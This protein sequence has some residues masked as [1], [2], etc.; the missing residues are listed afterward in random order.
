MRCGGRSLFGVV[1]LFAFALG[2]GAQARAEGAARYWVYWKS[3]AL[4]DGSRSELALSPRAVDRLGRHGRTPGSDP[5][6]YVVPRATLAP[7]LERGLVI[8]RISRFLQAAS[9]EMTADQ[10][11][12]LAVDPRILDVRPVARF[13]RPLEPADVSTSAPMPGSQRRGSA[14]DTDPRTLL[15]GDYGNAWDQLDMLGVQ[16]L[17]DRGYSG[18]GV[19]V[20]IFDTGFYKVHESLSGLDLIAEHDF[21]CGD[22]EVQW[23]PG[24][25]CGVSRSNDHGTYTWSTLGGFAPGNLIG[26]AYRA[27][28]A[29]AKTEDVSR[30]VHQEED[31]YVAALE[32]ADSLGADVVSSSLGYRAFDDGSEYTVAQL[33]GRTAPIT[34]ATDVAAD[35]GILVVTAMGNEGPGES[36]LGVPADGRRVVSVGAVDERGVLALFSSWGPTGDGRIKPD[37]V[38]MGVRTACAASAG[39]HVYARVNGTSLSTPLAAGLAALLIEAEPAWGPDSV[40]AALRRSGDRHEDPTNTMGWGVPDGVRALR[41]MD[42]RPQI[43]GVAWADSTGSGDG[44]GIPGWGETATLSLRVKNIGHAPVG[45]TSLWPTTHDARL[46]LPDSAAVAVPALTVGDSA[47][48]ELGRVSISGGEGQETLPIL[49]HFAFAGREIDRRVHLPVLPAQLVAGFKAEADEAGAVHLSWRLA[50][51]TVVGVQIY[52]KIGTGARTL[53]TETPLDPQT[54]SFTDR[55]GTFGELKYTMDILLAG[56]FVSREGPY[57][58][59]IAEPQRVFVGLPYPNPARAGA[60]QIPLAWPREDAPGVRIYTVS[61]RLCVRALSGTAGGGDYPSLVWDLKDDQG[62]EVPSGIYFVQAD[63][64]SARRVIV[65]R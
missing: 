41:I 51:P 19:L 35:R 54:R 65:V 15:A 36:T 6:D 33:D 58:L 55:P 25:A 34:V 18:E 1:L 63:G 22:D 9:V 4:K 32:W 43:A 30:E 44:N 27:E 62:R 10:A 56:D 52:R 48:V 47:L 28:F 31:N 14:L 7:I 26:P 64:G 2:V 60:V 16:E 39:P 21:V 8:K 40:A 17:H 38:A 50:S 37:V 49:V 23:L 45:P 13:V 5:R 3:T 59:S 29:L 46:S 57:Q 12:E 42:A 24:D 53:L 20:A 11:R 61:G